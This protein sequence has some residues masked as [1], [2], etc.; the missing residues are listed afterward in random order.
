MSRPVCCRRIGL[1]PGCKAFKPLGI[2][3]AGLERIA[4]GLDELEALRLADLEGLYHGD[5]AE[6]MGV[7]R[8]TF[9][10]IVEAA[11]RKVAEALVAGRLL[12]IEGGEV[13]MSDTLGE[14][15]PSACPACAQ[16]SVRRC[17]EHRG[18]GQRHQRT[19]RSET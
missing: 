11:R 4:L 3:A 15:K 5:A 1:K 14:S 19:R 2:P 18:R 12:V 17:H 9:G 13:T 7:S 6:R 8:A 16:V 10:R